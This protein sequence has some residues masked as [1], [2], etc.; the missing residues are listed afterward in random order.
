[1]REQFDWDAHQADV[2]IRTQM[3]IAV[4]R[5]A[6]DDIVI[7]QERRDEHDDDQFIVVQPENLAALFKPFRS[8]S[9]GRRATP[10]S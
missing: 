4:Y 5:N 9:R 8:R 10:R 3:A 7:R 2:P 1:M 6:D